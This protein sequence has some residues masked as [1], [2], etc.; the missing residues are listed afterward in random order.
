MMQ[1]LTDHWAV[2]AL[3]CSEGLSLIP[4]FKSNGIVQA[5]I[6]WLANVGKSNP[7]APTK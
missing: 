5:L 7:P 6:N 4:A 3:V 2:I 1:Y